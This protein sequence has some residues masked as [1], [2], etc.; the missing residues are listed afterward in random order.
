MSSGFWP[1]L[2]TFAN[3]SWS[4]GQPSPPSSSIPVTT[5]LKAATLLPRSAS[6]AQMAA[7][8]TDLPTS[9][10]VPVT[11]IPRT[12]LHSAPR[13]RKPSSPRTQA[14][15]LGGQAESRGRRNTKVLGGFGHAVLD[16]RGRRRSR[17]VRARRPQRG[18][19]HRLG[20]H[21]GGR[22]ELR[23]G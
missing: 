7:E 20:Q 13:T 6:A 21:A 15:R 22:A 11:K 10:P 4:G 14:R 16:L 17:H 18:A 1:A 2:A 19:A 3:S 8:T 12:V 23:A 9:V 5:G